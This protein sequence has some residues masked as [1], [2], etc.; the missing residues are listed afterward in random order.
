MFCSSSSPSSA[1]YYKYMWICALT[2]VVVN[3]QSFMDP[4]ADQP[5]L[6]TLI[7]VQLTYGQF[8]PDL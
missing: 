6:Q 3:D 7:S 4:H 1:A 2:N 8:H 5:D